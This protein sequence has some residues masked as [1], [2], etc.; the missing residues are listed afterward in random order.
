[1]IPLVA[2]ISPSTTAA[3]TPPP[4]TNLIKTFLKIQNIFLKFLSIFR[5]EIKSKSFEIR[6]QKIFAYS[7]YFVRTDKENSDLAQ[8]FKKYYCLL[9]LNIPTIITQL[10]IR[11]ICIG[12]LYDLPAFLVLIKGIV[13]RD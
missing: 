1:M 10:L 11:I 3:S 6:Y 8:Y 5:F 2:L 9:L 12:L 4:S 7:T 13:S